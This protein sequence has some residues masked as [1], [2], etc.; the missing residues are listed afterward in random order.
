MR[1]SIY[2]AFL[3]DDERGASMI[4]A[5]AAESGVTLSTREV[6]DHLNSLDDEEIDVE[7]TAEMLASAAGGRGGASAVV[8]AQEVKIL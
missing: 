8:N 6:I 4:V 7:L 3:E 1:N 2:A 5:F